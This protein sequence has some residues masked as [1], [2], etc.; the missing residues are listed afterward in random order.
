ML[1]AY[2]FFIALMKTVDTCTKYVP[3]FPGL[4]R[5]RL[6]VIIKET[7][8]TLICRPYDAREHHSQ[9]TMI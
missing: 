4:H 3:I 9:N 7:V 8:T 6:L 5:A 2:P 1:F